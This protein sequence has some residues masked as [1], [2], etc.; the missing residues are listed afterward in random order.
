[1]SISTALE[2]TM[3]DTSAMKKPFDVQTV[4]AALEE[5]GWKPARGQGLA[6]GLAWLV[7][8]SGELDELKQ[9]HEQ[10]RTR[11][12]ERV[13]QVDELREKFQKEQKAR[14][15]ASHRLRTLQ[16]E[17]AELE[18]KFLAGWEAERDRLQAKIAEIEARDGRYYEALEEIRK[19]VDKTEPKY[20]A[21]RH[22]WCANRAHRALTAW[23]PCEQCR[24]SHEC[25]SAYDE[26]NRG[27]VE[28]LDCVGSGDGRLGYEDEESDDDDGA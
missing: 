7:Q 25:E 23:M 18:K 4:Q 27:R 24:S 26:A 1:M 21:G 17:H 19:S 3:G 20:T 5:A 14:L 9:M 2:I 11:L 12:S 6:E 15:R 16:G 13:D 8:R 22:Q 10:I 28:G